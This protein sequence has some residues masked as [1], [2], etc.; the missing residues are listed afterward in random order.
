MY[1]INKLSKL[2]VYSKLDEFNK[3]WYTT[4]RFKKKWN[5]CKEITEEVLKLTDEI[6]YNHNTNVYMKERGV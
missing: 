2:W 6:V 3:F 1:N 5:N 4:I